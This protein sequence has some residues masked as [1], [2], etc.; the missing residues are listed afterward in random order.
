[1][2]SD[3]RGAAQE[4]VLETGAVAVLLSLAVEQVQERTLDGRIEQ[5][6]TYT[7][8]LGGVHQIHL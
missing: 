7:L 6:G 3:N 1:M 2:W 5:V 8:T 4:I